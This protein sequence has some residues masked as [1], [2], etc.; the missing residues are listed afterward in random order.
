MNSVSEECQQLKKDY[1]ACFNTWFKEKFLRGSTEDGCA[2]LFQSYQ[3]CVKKAIKERGID[4]WEVERNVLGTKDE[5][6][7]PDDKKKK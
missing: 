7:P 5:Q 6:V 1:D 3:S 4:V 2:V